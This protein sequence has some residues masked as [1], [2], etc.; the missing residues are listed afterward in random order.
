[1]P[2]SVRSR[3]QGAPLQMPRARVRPAPALLPPARAPG[4]P[5]PPPAA[6]RA[7]SERNTKKASLV[8]ESHHPE[9]RTRESKSAGGPE[10]RARE[11]ADPVREPDLSLERAPRSTRRRASVPGPPSI[12]DPAST[13]VVPHAR[14]PRITVR[15]CLW[16]RV[17]GGR[18]VR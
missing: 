14:A 2:P 18:A 5:A 8:F 7:I 10:S 9:P 17:L 15:G 4:S 3:E 16:I 13:M 1:M 12:L 11:E 6:F